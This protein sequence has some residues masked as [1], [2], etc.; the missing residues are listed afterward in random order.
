MG[1]R[2]TLAM[3]IMKTRTLKD[4]WERPGNEKAEKP[5]KA[6][7]NIVEQASWTNPVD[8]KKTFPQS[9]QLTDGRMIFDIGGNKWRVVAFINYQYYTLYIKFVGNHAEYDRDA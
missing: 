2:Y 1:G 3:R 9:D 7:I 4:Y 6:W 5:L 8:V